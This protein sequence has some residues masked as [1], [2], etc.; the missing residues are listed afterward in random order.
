MITTG[1][2]RNPQPVMA[3]PKAPPQD[4]LVTPARFCACTGETT[5]TKPFRLTRSRTVGNGLVFVTYETV[6]DA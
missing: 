3:M 4:R 1:G 5:G 2:G 6:R